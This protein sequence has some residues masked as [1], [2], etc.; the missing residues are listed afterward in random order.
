MSLRIDKSDHI[1]SSTSSKW[2]SLRFSMKKKNDEKNRS[3]I[4]II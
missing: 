1:L 2:K 4:Y 3:S